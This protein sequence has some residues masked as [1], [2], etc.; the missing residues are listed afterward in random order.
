MR[1]SSSS[2]SHT[3]SWEEVSRSFSAHTCPLT[4]DSKGQIELLQGDGEK[5]RSAPR[6]QEAL[7][8][9][10]AVFKYGYALK[11]IHLLGEISICN[12]LLFSENTSFYHCEGELY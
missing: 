11:S 6:A 2:G 4:E 10:G 5:G 12:L 8:S 7:M 9:C 1:D 3:Y